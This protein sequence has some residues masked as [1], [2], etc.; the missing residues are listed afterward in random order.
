M[1]LRLSYRVPALCA[2]AANLR[3]PCPSALGAFNCAERAQ[4]PSLPALKGNQRS[5]SDR[6]TLMAV[7]VSFDRVV[8]LRLSLIRGL[9]A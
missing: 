3:R 6:A 2:A 5:V 9:L 8:I 7:V 1:S 4:T